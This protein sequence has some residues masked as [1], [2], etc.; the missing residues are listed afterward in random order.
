MRLWTWFIGG[1]PI[2]MACYKHRGALVLRQFRIVVADTEFDIVLILADG[3][4][5]VMC[6]LFFVDSSYFT[7]FVK[8]MRLKIY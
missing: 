6:F 8:G 1:I 4:S 5:V 7:F 3:C 2:F